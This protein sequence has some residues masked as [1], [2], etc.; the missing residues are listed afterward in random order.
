MVSRDKEK[1]VF[2]EAVDSKEKS[3]EIWCKEVEEQ[4]FSTIQFLIHNSIDD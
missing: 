3:I 2:N 1:I 4:I